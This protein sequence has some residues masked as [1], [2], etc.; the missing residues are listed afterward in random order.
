MRGLK[1]RTTRKNLFR[2]VFTKNSEVIHLALIHKGHAILSYIIPL[3]LTGAPVHGK[4]TWCM[5]PA[6]LG[7]SSSQMIRKSQKSTQSGINVAAVQLQGK[8][9]LCLPFS[10]GPGTQKI[11][12]RPFKSLVPACCQRTRLRGL[13]ALLKATTPCV[14]QGYG[15]ITEPA[16]TS[17]LIST[18]PSENSSLKCT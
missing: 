5:F 2:E 6:W 11:R 4:R 1:E 13:F 14:P 16:C 17:S 12:E 18:I 3:D 10:T 8:S 7:S 9:Y 15:H